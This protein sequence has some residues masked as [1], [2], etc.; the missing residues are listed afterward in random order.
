[1]EELV[2][3][4]VARFRVEMEVVDLPQMIKAVLLEPPILVEEQA[5][6][7]RMLQNRELMAVRES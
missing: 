4:T 2:E 5:A 6:L 3:P 7:V 1:V